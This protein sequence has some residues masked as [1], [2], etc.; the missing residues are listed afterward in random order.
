MS[1]TEIINEDFETMKSMLDSINSKMKNHINKVEVIQ[2]YTPIKQII[3]E[4]WSD[5]CENG[6]PTFE[7]IKEK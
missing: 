1:Y 4:A 5:L 3:F 6:K 2:Y 7:Q